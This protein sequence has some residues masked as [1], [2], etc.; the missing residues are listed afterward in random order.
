[1][2]HEITENEKSE[3]VFVMLN[4]TQYR[5][6][7]KFYARKPAWHRLGIV[8]PDGLTAKAAL[9]LMQ[10]FSV[11]LTPLK[12]VRDGQV[13]DSKYSFVSRSPLEEGGAPITIGDPVY[14]GDL[15]E[16]KK[17]NPG[18]K[19]YQYSQFYEVISPSRFVDIW[20]EEVRY[21]NGDPVILES[22]GFLGDVGTKGLFMTVQ[23]PSWEI[24]GSEVMSYMMAYN[25]LA[26]GSTIS[27]WNSDIL[28][29]CMN[30]IMYGLAK[31]KQS[32]KIAHNV[33]A[34]DRLRKA[35]GDIYGT[36]L[37]AQ[38]LIKE[39]SEFLLKTPLSDDQFEKIVEETIK[40]PGEID[41]SRATKATAMARYETWA[42]RKNGALEMR[43]LT[44][45]AFRD[46]G[47]T[48]GITPEMV[49]TMYGGLQATTFAQSYRRGS[50]AATLHQM[51]DGERRKIVE[52][53]FARLMNAA[54]PGIMNKISA[55]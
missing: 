55:N 52:D 21:A 2:A 9:Q 47:M 40:L 15:E 17:L 11:F 38:T 43:A 54:K 5:L 10:P 6:D 45:D 22:M 14:T 34:S 42:R 3:K 27:V 51:I 46:G 20:D 19:D 12:Y 44:M 28:A 39:A 25:P 23:M 37:S 49:G 18:T 50:N 36:A 29:V 41:L 8:L 30:T 53:T 16:M 48:V 33:G 26:P 31:A 35:L 7:H 13:F 1:M 32:V 24:G 4:G